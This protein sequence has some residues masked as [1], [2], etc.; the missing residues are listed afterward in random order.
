MQK[1]FRREGKTYM[2]A[3]IRDVAKAAGVTIGTVSRALNNY[4][5]VN[6]HTRERIQRVARELGYTPNQMARS[7]SS[8]HMKRIALI[9]SGFL[10]D[11]M[12]NDF[13]TMLMKGIYQFASEHSIDIAMYVINSKTQLEKSYEQLCYEYNIAGA[14]LFGL[15]TTDPYCE[16]L[17]VSS[18][19]CVTIDTEVRG[20]HISNITLD[21]VAAFD[22]LAQYLIDRGHRRI[23]LVH[24]RKDAMVSMERLAGAYQAFE[25]NGLELTHDNIIYTNFHSEEA[26]TGVNE[27]FKAH[28]LDSVT[29]FLCMSDML[30]IGTIEALKA[31][32]RR[33]P[34]DYSVVG[35]DGLE[36]TNYTDPKITTVDQNIK[37]K[38]YE[39]AHLLYDMLNGTRNAQKLVLPHTLVERGS[40]KSLI[41]E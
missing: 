40:V 1:R 12:L 28:S 6:I 24:G 34:E 8:K 26:L 3:T 5:D 37:Q 10:E 30:A 11:T 4:E 9:L 18:R 22:E 38:G 27:Y 23:V 20:E 13:E 7:L 14:I 21:D 39:A 2:A 32:G 19:P 17:P 41:R 25:R 31:M 29:A 33:V 36:V 15:K 35:Y 16:A